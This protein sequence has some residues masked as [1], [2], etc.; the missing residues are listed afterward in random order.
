MFFSNINT[1]YKKI[2]KFSKNKEKKL[3]KS[4]RYVITRFNCKLND[5]GEN[6]PQ[7]RVQDTQNTHK[8]H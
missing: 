8:S 5:F 6:R 4:P 3:K 1:F 2:E 7:I